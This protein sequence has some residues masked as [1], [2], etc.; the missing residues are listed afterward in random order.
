MKTLSKE[1]Q[2]QDFLLVVK[3]HS[4]TN[5]KSSRVSISS[6]IFGKKKTYSWNYGNGTSV[7]D[8][9]GGVLI[10]KG[11]NV[12]SFCEGKKEDYLMISWDDGISL[13]GVK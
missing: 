3:Y 8:Q 9:I 7:F 11:I 12:L 1:Y 5:H 13:M 4:P 2:S 10:N 6:P